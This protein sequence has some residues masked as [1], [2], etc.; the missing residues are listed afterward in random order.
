MKAFQ[1]FPQIIVLLRG[2]QRRG[3]FHPTELPANVPPSARSL[4]KSHILARRL[5]PAEWRRMIELFRA[6]PNPNNFMG[7]ETYGGA[8]NALAPD[9]TAFWHRRAAVDVF[10]FSFSVDE[11]S[12][13]TARAYV[14]EFDRV[15]EPLSNGHSYQNYPNPGK[16]ELWKHVFR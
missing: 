12:R 6:S 3:G 15:A 4:A 11:A 5:T 16:Q 10:L 14:R 2:I 7:L 9:A 8:I 13:D 1:H